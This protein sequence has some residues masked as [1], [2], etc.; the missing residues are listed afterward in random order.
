[1]TLFTLGSSYSTKD[2]KAE[3][4][5]QAKK[6]NENIITRVRT[7]SKGQTT[8]LSTSAIED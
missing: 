1:M 5:T 8:W 3:Q 4:T 7:T 6:I 2:S